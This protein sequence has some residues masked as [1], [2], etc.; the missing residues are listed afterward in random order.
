MVSPSPPPSHLV[1]GAYRLPNPALPSG[2]AMVPPITSSYSH[3]RPLLLQVG[4]SFL[5]LLFLFLMSST[6]RGRVFL[7]P[8]LSLAP[9]VPVVPS[10]PYC[11]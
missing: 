2:V 9:A 11:I 10:L 5:L 3:R 6:R 4:L 8:A 1:G 7:V